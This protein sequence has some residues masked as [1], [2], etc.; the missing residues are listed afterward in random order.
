MSFGAWHLGRKAGSEPQALAALNLAFEAGC[1]FFDATDIDASGKPELLLGQALKNHQRDQAF[2]VTSGGQP[3]HGEPACFSE[4]HLRKALEKSLKHLDVEVIDL[5]QLHAPPLEVIQDA[6]IFETL[7]KF[8]TEGKIRFY[9]LSIHDPQEGIQAIQFGQI[10]T[11][12]AIYNLFDKRLEKQL[13]EACAASETGLIAREPLARG[14]LSAKYSYETTFEVDDNRSIWPRPLLQKR[15]MAANRFKPIIPAE[16]SGLAQFALAY[17]LSNPTV[18][19]VMTGYKTPEQVQEGFS[20]AKFMPLSC[21][22]LEATL[23][24]Q[25]LL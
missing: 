24:I 7:R 16:Y 11:V 5:Y 20:I 6:G 9:G 25:G 19:T 15:L 21:Q 13:I 14:S 18:S 2:I 23:Q 8:R 12:Q 3:A 4:A 10:D 17:P 22:T 1:N